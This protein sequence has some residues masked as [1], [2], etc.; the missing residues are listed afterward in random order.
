MINLE[1]LKTILEPLD[2]SVDV[3]ESIQNIDKIDKRDNEISRLKDENEQIR[4]DYDER[5]RKAFF[6]NEG[7]VEQHDDEIVDQEIEQ[8]EGDV[9]T[10]IT[11]DE[12]FK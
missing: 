1:E 8:S 4:K 5:F 9:N 12:L 3:L 6:R 7:L 2:L 10:N 11:F